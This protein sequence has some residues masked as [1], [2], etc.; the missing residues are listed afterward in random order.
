M[1]ATSVALTAAL[2][3]SFAMH[4]PIPT[5]TRE[6]GRIGTRAGTCRGA[7]GRFGSDS[8]KSMNSCERKV[9]C[10]VHRRN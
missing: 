2:C 8:R 7:G 6:G 5:M 10:R 3:D 1:S 9:A 4:H